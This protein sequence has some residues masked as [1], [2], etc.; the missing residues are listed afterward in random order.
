[1]SVQLPREV[2]Y[3]THQGGLW[4]LTRTAYRKLVKAMAK[5]E[6]FDLDVL[7]TQ[8]SSDVKCLSNLPEE[9]GA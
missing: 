4:R 8:L 9:E 3:V 2:V 1:M 7:G 6:P 5:G